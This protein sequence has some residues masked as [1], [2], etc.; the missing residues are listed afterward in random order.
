MDMKYQVTIGWSSDRKIDE[1]K[2]LARLSWLRLNKIKY[3]PGY[4][5]VEGDFGYLYHFEREE[6]AALFSLSWI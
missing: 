1:E 3:K 2:H 6:D 5:F 4:S